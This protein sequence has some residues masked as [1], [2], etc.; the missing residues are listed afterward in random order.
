[1]T[2]TIG[3]GPPFVAL[4]LF[5]I[6]FQ[7]TFT[8]HL[9][10]DMWAKLLFS[11]QTFFLVSIL[12]IARIKT[13]NLR[14][15]GIFRERFNWDVGLGLLITITPVLLVLGIASIVSVIDS[16]WPFLPYPIFGGPPLAWEFARHRWLI[17][18]LLAPIGE[19]IFFRGILL[20]A[21]RASYPAWIAVMS[22]ALIFMG[23]HGHLS[24][25]PLILGLMNG[26]IVLRTGSILPGII[27]HA[28][29]N[30]YGPITMQF[31]PNIFRYLEFL[32]A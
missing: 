24:F 32:Y 11:P 27:F 16:M 14:D 7:P 2:K 26:V 28:L 22:S 23:A 29:S 5:A 13:L 10:Q 15:L 6:F 12:F 25:G 1:M 3:L 30:M 9:P 8:R 18:L 4:I 31:F 21:I 19:E 20:R 17:L